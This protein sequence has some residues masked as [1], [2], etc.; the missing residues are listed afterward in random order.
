[1][2]GINK[3]GLAKMKLTQD[4]IDVGRKVINRH[5]VGDYKSFWCDM[6]IELEDYFDDHNKMYEAID[7]LYVYFISDAVDYAYEM[8]LGK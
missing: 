8:G 7:E 5:G 4:L 3:K 6:E 1:M 2:L